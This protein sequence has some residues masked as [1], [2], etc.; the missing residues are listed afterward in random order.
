M[1]TP[2][3]PMRLAPELLETIDKLAKRLKTTRTG[4]VRLAVHALA[5]RHRLEPPVRPRLHK[6]QDRG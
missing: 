6:H 3:T 2:I 5:R 4:A 1:P